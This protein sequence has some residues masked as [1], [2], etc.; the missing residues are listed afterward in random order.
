M[1]VSSGRSIERVGAGGV[2]RAAKNGSISLH[3][4]WFG[5]SYSR[6]QESCGNLVPSMAHQDGSRRGGGGQGCI[7]GKGI[8]EGA[9]EAVGRRLGEVAKAVGGGYCWLQMP[10]RLALGVRGTVAGKRLGA[11][12]GGGLPP[13]PFQ[14]IPAHP[15]LPGVSNT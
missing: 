10:L 6:A 12:D 3:G 15:P 1:H 13:P 9:P 5:Q 7:R 11:L 8:S 2:L 4:E 14:C